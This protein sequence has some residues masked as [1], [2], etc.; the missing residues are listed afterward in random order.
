MKMKMKTIKTKS[1][2]YRLNITFPLRN[3]LFS[4][5]FFLSF[6]FLPAFFLLSSSNAHFHQSTYLLSTSSNSSLTSLNIPLQIF[7]CPTHIALLPYTSLAILFSYTLPFLFSFLLLPLAVLSQL[8]SFL[9]NH[10]LILLHSSS[11]PP[12]PIYH[13]SL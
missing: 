7:H 12:F 1:T 4:S 2:F 8:L 3:V 11:P 6:C 10:L 13:F 9:Q 5:L